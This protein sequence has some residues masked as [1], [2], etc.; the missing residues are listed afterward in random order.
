M[1]SIAETEIVFIK[2]CDDDL[3][4]C[5]RFEAQEKDL[6]RIEKEMTS[7]SSENYGYIIWLNLEDDP[8]FFDSAPSL[9]D[10]FINVRIKFV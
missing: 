9:I 1:K 3:D 4:S 2:Q 6:I 7:I 5:D 8:S 10:H